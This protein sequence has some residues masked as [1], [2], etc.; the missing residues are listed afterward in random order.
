[1]EPLLTTEEVA[2]YLRVEVVTVRRL[3]MRG[4]L[5]AYRIGSEFRFTASDVEGFVKSQR[6]TTHEV[7]DKFSKFTERSRKVMNFAR[8]EAIVLQHSYMGTEHLLLGLLRE[9]EGI[10]AVTLVRSGLD[11]AAVRQRVMDIV[12]QPG[13]QNAEGPTSQI[14]A[15]MQSVLGM[16]HASSEHGLTKRARKVIELSVDEARLLGH[17]YIGTEHL[18]LGM[19]REGDGIAAHVLIQGCGLQLA[20][21]RELV[22]HILQNNALMAALES[23]EQAA[24]PSSGMNEEKQVD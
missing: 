21:V 11:L 10:G 13:Q 16:G 19:L 14:K 23:S 15:A 20:S 17:Q 7:V 9:E 6:V 18:L 22:T 5:P 12:Q 2:E 8:E 1:M 4:E 24:S 3:I